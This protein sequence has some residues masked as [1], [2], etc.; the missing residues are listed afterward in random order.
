MVHLTETCTV[1][2]LTEL[3]CIQNLACVRLFHG[4]A[5]SLDSKLVC[6]MF[7]ISLTNIGSAVHMS[8]KNDDSDP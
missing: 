8:S 4:V 7:I 2:V 6:V 1:T 5:R 3:V